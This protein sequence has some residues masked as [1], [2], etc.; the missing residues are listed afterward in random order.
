[1]LQDIWN[2]GLGEAA[3]QQI[4]TSRMSAQ[5]RSDFRGALKQSRLVDVQNVSNFSSLTTVC[6]GTAV[7]ASEW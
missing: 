5:G 1:M 6:I 4:A 2:G 7:F 3:L